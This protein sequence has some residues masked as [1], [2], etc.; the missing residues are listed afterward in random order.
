MNPLKT[1]RLRLTFPLFIPPSQSA[2]AVI[3][4]TLVATISEC[5]QLLLRRFKKHTLE[6]IAVLSFD[7]G[8]YDDTAEIQQVLMENAVP[9]TFFFVGEDAKRDPARVRSLADMGMEIGSHTRSHAKLSTLSL[10]EQREEIRGGIELV[11]AAAGSPV[12]NFRPP[13]GDFNADTLQVLKETDQIASLWNVDPRDYDE[14]SAAQIL[15]RV[16]AQAQIP[17]VFLLHSGRPESLQALPDVIKTYRDLGYTFI[18]A[19][20]LYNRHFSDTLDAISAKIPAN[21]L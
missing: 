15:D 21:D 2:S 17:S 12:R 14:V 5:M 16:R 8:P 11:E 20:E 1:A 18:T 13:Y 4:P 7:D 3:A 10:A 19:G 9:A 6:K